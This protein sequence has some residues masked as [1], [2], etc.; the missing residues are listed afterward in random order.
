[1]STP[2][3]IPATDDRSQR[4]TDTLAKI[5]SD[6]GTP[7]VLSQLDDI[8]PDFKNLIRDFA[9]GEIYSRPGLDLKS[10]QLATVAALAAMNNS[11]LELKAHLHGALKLGWT[12]TELVELLM[13]I[14]LYA[15]FPATIHGLLIAKEVFSEQPPTRQP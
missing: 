14:S 12:Q 10:R 13:Q 6:W 2:P 4:G 8:A 15:G 1:M 5:H 9:F 3:K 11:P 7:N